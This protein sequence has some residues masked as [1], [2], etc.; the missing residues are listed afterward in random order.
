VRG[1]FVIGETKKL[2][3]LFNLTGIEKIVPGGNG[4]RIKYKEKGGIGEI[5]SSSRMKRV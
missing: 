4:W 5:Q 2:V 1:P 3:E